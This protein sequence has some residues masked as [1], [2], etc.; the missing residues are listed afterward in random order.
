[1]ASLWKC[2]QMPIFFF[3]LKII[4]ENDNKGHKQI[5]RDIQVENTDKIEL[6]MPLASLIG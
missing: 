5:N 6:R 2:R 1:M 4:L 3:S